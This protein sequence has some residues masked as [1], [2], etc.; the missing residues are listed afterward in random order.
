MT[1]AIRAVELAVLG[2]AAW[3]TVRLATC[4][5]LLRL[6]P[7]AYAAVVGAL[8]LGSAGLLLVALEAPTVLHPLALLAGAVLVA[9]TV[10]A[11]TGFE[12]QGGVPPGSLSLA[13][14]IR[15]LVNQRFL[16]ERARQCGPIFKLAQ[17]HHKVVCVVGLERG[18]RLFRDHAA[19]LEPMATAITRGIS[20]GF[21]RYMDE[22]TYNVYGP[23]FRKAFARSVM[24]PAAPVVAQASRRELERAAADCVGSPTGGVRPGPYLDRIVHDSFSRALYGVT[25]G[26]DEQRRLTE[27]F[28]ALARQRVMS[29]IDPPSKEAL[30]GLRAV[31]AERVAR[32]REQE[33]APTCALTELSFLDPRMPDETCYDNLLLAHKIAGENVS[34]LLHWVLEILGHRRDWVAR[35]RIE[36]SSESRNGPDL[37]ERI[38]LETLRLAQSE[39]LY[40][41]IT[42]DFEYEGFRMPAGWLIRLCVWESHRSEEIFEDPEEFNPDRFL[43]GQFTSAQYS[44]FGWGQHACNGVPLALLVSQA[45]VTELVRGYDWTVANGAPEERDFRHWSHWRPSSKLELRLERAKI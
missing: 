12:L 42:E 24:E 28:G 2:F 25:P 38:V 37:V 44:P 4:G 13:D 29:P 43:A 16:L 40:R 1:T 6:F 11:R 5:A 26:S 34:G 3:P 32:L 9:A 10:R 7:L 41:R 33:D 23:L 15:A 17:F 19:S 36:P 31:L 39:H 45:V 22:D 35:A 21:L 20:G 14:S 30:V 27:L 18:H 8:A